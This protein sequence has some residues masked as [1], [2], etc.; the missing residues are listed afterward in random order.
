MSRESTARTVAAPPPPSIEMLPLDAVE[1]SPFNPRKTFADL[2]ELAEDVK[3]RGVLQP[4]LVRP[5][6][7]TYQ[8][9]FGARRYRAAKLAKLPTIPAMV[10]AMTDVEALEVAIVENGKRADVHPLEEADAYRQLHEKHGYEVETIAAKLGKSR[11]YVYGRLKLRDLGEKGREAFFKGELSASVALLV[12]RLPEKDQV[13]ALEEICDGYDR[14]MSYREAAD[15]IQSQYMQDLA[16]AP[17]DPADAL[18]VP[19][20]GA[21]SACPKRSG[22]NPDLFGDIDGADVCT[23]GGCFSEKARAATERKIEEAQSSGRTVL[24][25]KAAEKALFGTE[26]AKPDEKCWEDP[27]GR[28]W[29]QL[30]KKAGG[31]EPVVALD[32]NLI[33]K[34]LLSRQAIRSGLTK[35]GETWTTKATGGDS[36]SKQQRAREKA[37]RLRRRV[38]QEAMKDLASEVAGAK[39]DLEFWA[40]LAELQLEHAGYEELHVLADVRDFKVKDQEA[41]RRALRKE[42]DLVVEPHGPG[43]LQALV[44]QL[45]VAG[46]AAGGAYSNG[47]GKAFTKACAQFGVDLK[48]I[49][50][51]LRAEQSKPK[52]KP[53]PTTKK[54]TKAKKA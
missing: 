4:V 49:E 54:K 24:E 43:P 19:S 34:E 6:Q 30:A 15:F 51:G 18:L 16:K 35:A 37:Q 29:G 8:L 22:A 17:F 44:L 32:K 14:P 10:R 3:L 27:K 39:P 46:G 25:G 31:V 48:A 20:A 13:Q 40:F 23:D 21:C 41:V 2:E 28:T 53:T 42:L 50:K 7:G 33:A 9:V 1:E 5:Y 36:Y 38:V 12:A 47:Y 26:Y 11:A 45:L 52:A